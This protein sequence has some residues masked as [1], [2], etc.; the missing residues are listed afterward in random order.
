M[1]LLPPSQCGWLGLGYVGCDGSFTCRAW[2]HADA[3]TSPQAIMHE[4]GHNLYMGHATSMEGGVVN[5]Y[6]DSTCV[7]VSRAL[8]SGK[9]AWQ[10]LCWWKTAAECAWEACHTAHCLCSQLTPPA[11]HPS[12][13]PQG[14][15]CDNRCPNTPHAWQMGWLSVQQLDGSSLTPGA[16]VTATLASSSASSQS[17]LR[18]VPNWAAGAAPVFLG[19]RS[20]AGGDAGLAASLAGQVHVYTANI[21]NTFDAGASE[22]RWEGTLAAGAAWA[23]PAAGL[24]VRVKS[25][26]ATGATLTVCRKAGAETAA[27]CAAGLDNDCNGLVGTADPACPKPLAQSIRPVPRRQVARPPRGLAKQALLRRTAV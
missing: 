15:C 25:V 27:S 19:V 26:G 9:G 20:T 23:Q 24:V 7:M 22:T 10:G 8:E 21:S 14:H 2:I 4:L 3:W 13:N 1:Y 11:P 18:V 17:G 5:D 6:G 16:T 12:P